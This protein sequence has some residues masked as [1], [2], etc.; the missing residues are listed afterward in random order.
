MR[1]IRG[2]SVI[3]MSSGAGLFGRRTV[4]Q[5]YVRTPVRCRKCAIRSAAPKTWV[6]RLPRARAAFTSFSRTIARAG[7]TDA[8]RGGG[9][10]EAG[11]M[12]SPKQSA[13]KWVARCNLRGRPRLRQTCWSA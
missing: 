9:I 10:G 13:A 12:R 3:M 5:K 6:A 2:G 11:A 4:Q 1:K 8:Q 7:G